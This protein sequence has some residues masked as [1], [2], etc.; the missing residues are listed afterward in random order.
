MVV[1]CWLDILTQR[2][3]N[4]SSALGVILQFCLYFRGG[5]TFP[6]RGCGAAGVSREECNWDPGSRRPPF[7][8]LYTKKASLWKLK[9]SHCSHRQESNPQ[10]WATVGE[11]YPNCN[12]G[13]GAQ[14]VI[15]Q[16]TLDNNGYYQEL[17]SWYYIGFFKI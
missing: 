6:K 4:D 12:T 13:T 10:H 7:K 8:L 17:S 16:N 1:G 15:R 3:W 9:N 14:L 2:C 11:R 5:P